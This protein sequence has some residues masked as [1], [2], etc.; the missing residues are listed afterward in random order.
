MRQARLVLLVL[1]MLSLVSACSSTDKTIRA[2]A[3]VKSLEEDQVKTSL[4]KDINTN[5]REEY[6]EKFSYL[7]Q[8]SLE[9][10]E[11][12]TRFKDKRNLQY[13]YNFTPEDMVLVY[14]HCLSISDPDLIYTITLNEGQLP[15]QD[16]FRKDYFEYASNYDSETA[17]HYRYYDSIKVDEST[18]EENKVTVLITV[19]I[20][21][22]THT[23]A[24]GLQ[25]EDQV[26]KLDIYPMIKEYINK[27]SKNKTK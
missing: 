1:S 13:L 10:Q 25:K 8:L 21:S 17:V 15:D 18:A 2:E 5:P 3:P 12:F 6:I 23:M 14:L 16:K 7:K 19:S 26:W 4:S 11:A 24:L 27:A 9:K 22:M 20:E